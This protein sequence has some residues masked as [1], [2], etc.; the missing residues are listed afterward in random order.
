MRWGTASSSTASMRWVRPLKSIIALLDGV[1]VNVAV[2]G[3][4]AGSVTLGHRFHHPDVVTIGSADDYAAKLS[5]CHVIPD[6][7][8]RRRLVPEKATILAKLTD[9]QPVTAAG[10]LAAN[11]GLTARAKP[12]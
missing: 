3:V 10:L 12:P 1:E 7:A 8:E 5:A 11:P 2:E 6:P 4:T 9:L